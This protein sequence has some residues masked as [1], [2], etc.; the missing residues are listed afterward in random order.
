[1]SDLLE[2]MQSNK[3]ES[4]GASRVKVEKTNDLDHFACDDNV[5]TVLATVDSIDAVNQEVCLQFSKAILLKE[6]TEFSELLVVI[7]NENECGVKE[8]S[9]LV[10]P[11]ML[12]ESNFDL[13][14]TDDLTDAELQKAIDDYSDK[15]SKKKTDF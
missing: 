1:M 4:K 9:P 8:I 7:E 5:Q 14:L 11:I 12:L 6:A 3:P 10:M 2:S 15:T 13:N